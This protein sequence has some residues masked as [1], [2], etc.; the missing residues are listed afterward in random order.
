[1]VTNND[2]ISVCICTYKRPVLLGRLLNGLRKQITDGKFTYSI[3]VVDNDYAQSAGNTIDTFKKNSKIEIKYLCEPEQ[4]IAL[5]RNKAVQNVNGN[6]IAFIDDDEIPIDRWL[7]NL[8]KTIKEYGA[9]GVL[10]PVKPKFEIQ[11]PEWVIKGRLCVRDSF[12]TGTILKN[13]RYTRTGNVL[14]LRKLFSDKKN[15]FNSDFGKTGG[16]DVDF[17]NRMIAHGYIFIWNDEAPVYEEL[18]PERF[19]RSYF[20]KRALLRC[21][22]NSKNPSVASIIKSIIAFLIYT[23]SMPLF[24]LRG[25]HIFMKYLIKD[26]D[27]IGKLLG[28]CGLKLV[29][30]RSF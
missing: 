27:H 14:L 26:C 11:P 7:L 15:L 1:M 24:L 25:Q 9:D 5:A 18:P 29:K 3:V 4:N 17:F 30:E 13:P 10:G 8:Y 28:I 6:F 21:T 20:L 2:H 23:T 19:T 16:E 22:I 12:K